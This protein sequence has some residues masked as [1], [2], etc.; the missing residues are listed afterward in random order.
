MTA[1]RALPRLAYDFVRLGRP[2]F[3]AGGIA[4][5]GLGLA[6][7]HYEGH[8]ISPRLWL[9]GQMAVSSTQ[10]A[11]HYANDYFDRT[12]DRDNPGRTFWSGGSGVLVSGRLPAAVALAAA[13][14]LSALT[15]FCLAVLRFVLGAPALPLAIGILALAIAWAYSA[16]PF[17]LHSRG[18]GEIT[19]ALLVTGATP[20]FAYSL[21]TGGVSPL[22]LLLVAPTCGAGLVMLLGAAFPDLDADRATGKR[23]L[24]VRL[25][26]RAAA[27]LYLATIAA[28]YA[29]WLIAVPMGAPALAAV[30]LVTGLPL[31]LWLVLRL[32]RGPS[33]IA[34]R[35]GWWT[36][37]GAALLFL[38]ATGEAAALLALA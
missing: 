32:R 17:R 37:G 20:L 1:G 3:L 15:V 35:F 25:G 16:P 36:F 38:T 22:A 26:Y 33:A 11:T 31:A 5:F 7:A 10:L 9:W 12:G 24:V 13:I 8:L 28:I 2:H 27:R 18:V 34:S 23:T 30:G 21:H 4:L 29:W 19:A 6:I 14:G